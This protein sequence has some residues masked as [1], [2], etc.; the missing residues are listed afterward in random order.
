[1]NFSF[2]IMVTLVILFAITG[3]HS[4]KKLQTA[5]N[6][7]DTTVAVTSTLP[8]TDSLSNASVVLKKLQNNK[9]RFT[10]FSSKVKVQYEDR[11]GKQPDFN[12]FIRLQKD[13]VL[14][15]SINATFLNIEAF[16]IYITPDTLIILNKLD[17]VVEYH[18]FNYIES[19]AKIPMTFKVLQNLIIGNPIYQGDSIVSYRETENHI[20]IGTAGNFFKNLLTISADNN[21]IE[22]SKLDDI[23][24]GQNRTADLIYDN[25]DQT[26]MGAF[27]TYR[28][29]TIAEKTKVDIRLT[30]RQYEFNKEL[31][32]PFN[33]PRNFKTK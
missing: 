17:R 6:K 26:G 1:M 7:K 25:Y 27:A 23:E 4:T 31:S 16:R 19:I 8:V 3:C 30:F 9:I 10:T 18:P 24:V 14:W 15:I 21:Y 33:I 2:K 29:I 20:L 32:F 28:D 5:I 11:N 12:A 22:K 13:S